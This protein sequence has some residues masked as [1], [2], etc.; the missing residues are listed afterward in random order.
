MSAEYKVSDYEQ[1]LAVKHSTCTGEQQT[2]TSERERGHWKAPSV[3]YYTLPKHVTM[4]YSKAV[5]M[6]V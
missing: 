3:V 6:D 2:W 1:T 4:L 5:S